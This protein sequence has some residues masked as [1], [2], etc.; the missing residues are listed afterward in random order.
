MDYVAV[1]P[2]DGHLTMTRLIDYEEIRLIKCDVM[3]TDSGDPNSRNAI[4][5]VR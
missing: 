3:A 4:L 1:D 5:Q 2:N